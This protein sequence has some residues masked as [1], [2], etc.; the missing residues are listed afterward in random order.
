MAVPKRKQAN[1]PTRDHDGKTLLAL[2]LQGF[3]EL[4]PADEQAEACGNQGW[5][6]KCRARVQRRK[7]HGADQEEN[8]DPFPSIWDPMGATVLQEKSQGFATEKGD[9]WP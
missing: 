6:W 1:A 9:W 8:S 3:R 5:D 7:N 4:Q 2:E